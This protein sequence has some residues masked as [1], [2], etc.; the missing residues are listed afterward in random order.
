MRQSPELY[1][2]M[3]FSHGWARIL[4]VMSPQGD[5]AA[6]EALSHP[7]GIR[8]EH[9]AGH[10]PQFHEIREGAL[11]RMIREHGITVLDKPEWDKAKRRLRKSDYF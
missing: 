4:T 9:G 5:D 11:D 10:L 7:E 8:V 1:G 6:L 3:L 2:L